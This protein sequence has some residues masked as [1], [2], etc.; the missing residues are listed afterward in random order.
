[1]YFQ[2]CASDHDSSHKI[3]PQAWLV[4][5]RNTN[6][7][8]HRCAGVLLT[9]VL[10]CHLSGAE[11]AGQSGLVPHLWQLQREP[12]GP[13]HAARLQEARSI[14]L[15]QPCSSRQKQPLLVANPGRQQ[16]TMTHDASLDLRRPSWPVML[17][18]SC[19]FRCQQTS[20]VRRCLWAFVHSLF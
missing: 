11:E 18:A 15:A 16:V 17:S 9:G 7:C 5:A 2:A 3:L 4:H 19:P 13:A 6:F 8:A 10:H 20:S 1:M 14:H 12:A